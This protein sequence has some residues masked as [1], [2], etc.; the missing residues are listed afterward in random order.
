MH[1][2]IL[3]TNGVTNAL[4]VIP[5]H[6]CLEIRYTVFTNFYLDASNEQIEDISKL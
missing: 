3:E 5:T 2:E 6:E 1:L 4:S